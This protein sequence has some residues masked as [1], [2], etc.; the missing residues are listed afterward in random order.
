[1]DQTTEVV[2][3]DEFLQWYR[4]L[5]DEDAEKVTKYID[6]LE[7]LGVSLGHPY[8]SAIKGSEYALR[9]LRLVHKPIRIFYAFDPSRSA[10]VIIAGD[11]SGEKRF[12]ERMIPAA[13][14]I[15]KQYLEEQDHGSS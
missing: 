2:V 5:G 10:V 3:T 7:T 6:L 13:E 4:G 9:E 12:Y 15:W 11:K 1:M 8:S 14:R